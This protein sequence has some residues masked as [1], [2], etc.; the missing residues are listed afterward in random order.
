MLA[1]KMGIAEIEDQWLEIA[2]ILSSTKQKAAKKRGHG[3]HSVDVQ[4]KYF[5]L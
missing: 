3:I 1:I 2:T 4:I 5:A